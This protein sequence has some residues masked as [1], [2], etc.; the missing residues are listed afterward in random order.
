[1]TARLDLTYVEGNPQ[2]GPQTRLHVRRCV[3]LVN[4]IMWYIGKP[5]H[6]DADQVLAF[7]TKWCWL[8]SANLHY[9]ATPLWLDQDTPDGNRRE[10]FV[11]LLHRTT[12]NASR[13]PNIDTRN[14]TRARMQLEA[15]AAH[16]GQLAREARQDKDDT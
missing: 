5:G 1:M 2:S 7:A 14:N 13:D 9:F 15:V 12:I 11:Q 4:E 6:L 8:F 10:L 3:A 16:F